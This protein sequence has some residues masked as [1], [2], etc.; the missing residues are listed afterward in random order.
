MKTEAPRQ[1]G[2]DK[3]LPERNA[4]KAMSGVEIDVT[5]RLRTKAKLEQARGLMDTVCKRGNLKFT[6]Q[7]V[8]ENKGAAE[9]DESGIN[10]RT[11]VSLGLQR[12]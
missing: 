7:R 4:G 9:P 12:T 10:G 3:E 5:T 1:V 6:Y 8:I 11:G 2:T